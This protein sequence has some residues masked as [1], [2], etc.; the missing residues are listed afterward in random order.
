MEFKLPELGEGIYEAELVAWQV[1]PGDAVKRGQTLMEVLTDK[2]TMEVPAPFAGTIQKLNA[3]PGEPMKVGDVILDYQ[4]AGQRE[5]E[6]PKERKATKTASE[7]E[8]EE[9]EEQPEKP[10]ERKVAKAAP[11]EEEAEKPHKPAKAPPPEETEQEPEKPRERK[12]AKA[13][14]V[15]T[16]NGPSAEVPVRAAPS[17]RLMARK[18]GID[19]SHIP[20]SGPDGRILIE[21]L[22]RHLQPGGKHRERPDGPPG[23][24]GKPGQHIKL[25]G[26]RR[27]I[28]EHL[29]HSK[30]TIPHYS[31]VD[32]CDV[33][34]LVRLRE[35]LREPFRRAGVKITYLPFVIKAA[36]AA[37]QEVPLVNSSL[38]DEA[39]E[40]ILHDR[41]HIGVAVATPSGLIVPVVHDADK[42]NLLE[43]A[44][45]VQRLSSEARTGKSKREDLMGGTFTVTSIGNI[46]GLLSTP[47]IHHPQVA[48][49]G[50]GKIVRRPV[51]DDAG[52]VRG[53]DLVYLSFSFD[54][55]VVDG[56]VGAVFANAVKKSLENPVA[57]LMPS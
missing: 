35:G 41:Y 27:K 23:D 51:F 22:S 10:K 14:P 39:G 38:D 44:R 47:I 32:E 57:M 36:V 13:M 30:H 34:E 48:I 1:K 28:A 55:R 19:L 18:L 45:E 25:V 37:L 50:V 17:V 3:E 8:V 31:Y 33:S 4:E 16:K 24:F 2:A 11:Q 54:H 26:L 7:A 53:A 40:I 21:D 6:K 9:Q 29:V 15:A 20:G 43:I 52:Q 56:A 49:L 12:P 42:K 5:P 46:G